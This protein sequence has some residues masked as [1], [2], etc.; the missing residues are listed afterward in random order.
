V[1]GYAANFNDAAH[2]AHH[3]GHR[4]PDAVVDIAEAPPDRK[5]PEH[6]PMTYADVEDLLRYI[7]KF[8]MVLPSDTIRSPNIGASLGGKTS[9]LHVNATCTTSTPA[10]TPHASWNSSCSDP[11]HPTPTTG[12]WSA[13]T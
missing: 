9:T 2:M 4:L 6:T 12:R 8:G 7:A 3:L 13:S 11:R 10:T 5:P 1:F